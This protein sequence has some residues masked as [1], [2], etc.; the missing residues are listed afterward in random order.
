[1]SRGATEAS[2]P[3]ASSARPKMDCCPFSVLVRLVA[4][5]LPG[6]GGVIGITLRRVLW[7]IL[8]WNLVQYCWKTFS[9][10][11]ACVCYLIYAEFYLVNDVW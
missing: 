4:H 9:K 3:S 6:E 2:A 7:A 10:F 11:D 5:E 8:S 1:M